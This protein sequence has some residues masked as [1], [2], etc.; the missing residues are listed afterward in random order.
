[1][2]RVI[3]VLCCAGGAV[4]L[5]TGFGMKKEELVQDVAAVYQKAS[6]SGVI[7][8]GVEAV[9]QY[10]DYPDGCEAVSLY[11][12]MQYYDSSITM[13]DVID[14]LP[15]ADNPYQDRF[16]MV[17]YDPEEYYIGNPAIACWGSWNGPIAQA[18]NTL[19]GD[20]T[21]E[22]GVSLSEIKAVLDTGNPVEAWRYL[23]DDATYTEYSTW[24]DIETGETIE[25]PLEMHAVVIYGYDSTGFWIADPNGGT[26]YHMSYSA[27]EPLFEGLGSRIVYRTV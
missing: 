14:A 21:A 9:N 17:G 23:D 8:E 24:T 26:T 3:S 13:E 10:P 4:A 1:M 15:I 12:L 16:G 7:L 11:M 2:K 19:L 22:T 20:F 27:F 25:Y 6:G 5:L 18:A